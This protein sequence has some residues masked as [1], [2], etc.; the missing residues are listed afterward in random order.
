MIKNDDVDE[1]D[2]LITAKF[3]CA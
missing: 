3:S 2:V 1:G